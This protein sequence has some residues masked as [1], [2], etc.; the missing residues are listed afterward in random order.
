MDPAAILERIMAR[1][2]VALVMRVLDAYGRAAGGLL[3]NGL[4]FAALFAAFPLVLLILGIAGLVV[5][6]PEAQQ[7]LADALKALV[8]PLADFVDQGMAALSTNATA[9]SVLGFI[10]VVWAVSQLYVTLD[11]AFSRIFAKH[12]ERDVVRRT[13]RGFLWVL[14]LISVVVGTILLGVVAT[15]IGTLFPNEPASIATLRTILGG[16]PFLLA[17]GIGL[18]FVIYRTLPPGTPSVRAI[19]LPAVIVGIAV[20]ALSQLFLVLAPLLV[21]AARLAGSLAT[22]FIALAWLSFTFQALLYGAAWVRIREEG[23]LPP[24]G[25]APVTGAPDDP[26]AD[27]SALA[28]PAAPAEPGVGRE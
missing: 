15:A 2:L 26:A 14:I 7:H 10:G 23:P 1:P 25:A 16:W 9:A 27:G 12:Q 4:A 17:M 3:A 6:D 24:V 22:A 20:V 8:P 28:A 13:L 21:G 11:V 5:V 18:V 19:W